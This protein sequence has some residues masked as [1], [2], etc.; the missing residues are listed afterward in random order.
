MDRNITFLANVKKYMANK[1]NIIYGGGFRKRLGMCYTMIFC[2]KRLM[3]SVAQYNFNFQVTKS[4]FF[5]R[6]AYN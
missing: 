4:K 1:I 6:S 2:R 3:L 5:S